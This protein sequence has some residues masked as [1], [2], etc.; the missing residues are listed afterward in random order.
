MVGETISHYRI[1]DKLGGGGMG[2]VYKAE[3]TKLHRLVALKFLPEDSAGDSRS[4]ERLKREAQAASAL[5]HP[6]ICTIY[7]ID[8]FEGHSFIAMEYLEGRTLRQLTENKPLRADL[9]LDLA[10]QIAD[11]L[12]AAHAKGIIHRD[13][14]P[15]NIFVTPR[16]QA[17]ILD[18]GLAKLGPA[19]RKLIEGGGVSSLPTV[20][21]APT[22]E[23][24]L[25]SPGVAVGTVAYMSPEQ[26]LGEELDVRTDLFSFGAVLYEMATGRRAF[27]GATTAAVHDA[28]LN[29]APVSPLRLNPELPQKLEEI[30]NKAL[31]KDRDLRYQVASEMRTD[32]KRLKRDSD[33]GRIASAARS[34]RTGVV[35]PQGAEA[36]PPVRDSASI[37]SLERSLWRRKW[38]LLAAASLISLSIVGY[39]F[40][41]ANRSPALPPEIKLR[42]LT[43]SSSE[44]PIRLGAIS[45]DGKYFAYSDLK[46][47]H[48][49]LIGTGETQDVPQPEGLNSGS[50][51]W[52]VVRWFPDGTR[53]LANARNPGM[54][55][56]QWSAQGSSIWSVPVLGGAPRKIRDDAEAFSISP[57]GST[58][59]FGA[60]RSNSIADREIWLMGPDGDQARKLFEASS[61]AAVGNAFWSPDGR[62]IAYFEFDNSGTSLKS[63]D[64]NGGP[65]ATILT[66]VA[67]PPLADA[68]WL[69]DGRMLYSRVEQ[70]PNQDT[71]NF[72]VMPMNLR[73]GA[74]IEQPRRLTNFAGF[75]ASNSSVTSDGKSLAFSEW[76]TQSTVYVASVEVGGQRISTPSRL[77]LTDSADDPQ[78]WTPDSKFVIFESNR[79]GSLGIFKQALDSDTAASIA[80]E[81]GADA[82]QV[83]PDGASLLY[84]LHP[85]PDDTSAPDRMMRVPIA[86]GPPQL[87]LNSDNHGLFICAK[88]PAKFCILSEHPQDR[89]YISFM[90]VDPLKGLGRELARFDTDPG[91][92]ALYSWDLSPDGTRI[93]IVN[94]QEARIRILSL[95]GQSSR[96]ITVQGR[97]SLQFVA[98][99]ADGRGLFITS[100]IPRGYALLHVDLQGNSRVLWQ[101]SGGLGP[102]AVPSPDGR[103]LAIDGWTLA[104]NFW[105]MENF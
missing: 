22:E 71:C 43:F 61:A 59:A 45:P 8:V 32:L 52:Q 17:K 18:F 38:R 5:N 94:N 98:W 93:A 70:P 58:I 82:V 87:V 48:I 23:E 103:H 41:R 1:L 20:S 77:T 104:S 27:D 33:S 100:A 102:Y 15:A 73:T 79:N 60:N 66:L 4:L 11:G 68:L 97:D 36:L 56:S 51:Y 26:A 24:N 69:P 83:S 90:A 19:H 53:F 96:D 89:K 80:T 64:R 9:L 44:N 92:H 88:A 75:C 6:N 13:I 47:M 95:Q 46:G 39:A 25:T 3:D 49:R 74:P 10:I 16:G 7:D 40:W 55:S 72:W 30:L 99:A 35:R 84:F 12:D 81:P 2:V 62:R 65:A 54:D 63:R 31:E 76:R 91:A 28:I 57:D 105:L 34:H 86:G 29:R 21:V 37:V 85:K 50:V 14:K 67:G 42:Q 78:A 101:Q